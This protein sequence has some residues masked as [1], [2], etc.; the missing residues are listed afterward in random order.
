MSEIEICQKCGKVLQYC[1]CDSSNKR[2][3]D[4]VHTFNKGAGYEG[5][6]EGDIAK[7]KLERDSAQA[8][9]AL[10]AQKAF[11]DEKNAVIESYPPHMQDKISEKIG[12][13][14]EILETIKLDLLLH[15]SQQPVRRRGKAP[16]G[17]ASL[18]LK[19]DETI[20]S[21]QENE[22]H[23]YIDRLFKKAKLSRDPIEKSEA[24]R[25]ISKLF[26]EYELG[27]SEFKDKKVKFTVTQCISCGSVLTGSDA[28]AF[29]AR[30]I[31]CPYCSYKGGIVREP[32]HLERY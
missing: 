23:D 27:M 25:E 18:L 14:P 20:Q 13:S 24:E 9:L 28:Q 26:N 8:N 10:I 30:K 12:D 19:D 31:P 7:I 29:V 6:I 11:E 17:K 5:G 32:Q 3:I 4:I 16:S 2:R 21:G 15:G 22:Y 1:T